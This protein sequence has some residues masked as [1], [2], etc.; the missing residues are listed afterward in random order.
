MANTD[1]AEI[2]WPPGRLAALVGGAGCA[3]IDEEVLARA[4]A[5]V[6]ALQASYVEW[7]WND[8]GILEQAHAA[9]LA[10]P[11]ARASEIERIGGAAHDIRGQGG[12]FGYPLMTTIGSSLCDFCRAITRRDDGQLEVIRAHIDA[13]KAVIDNRLEGNG[14]A[15]GAE[16]VGLLEDA[17]EKH[18]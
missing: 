18:R 12:S 9:A 6:A 16:L 11:S 13:M 2:I 1:A 8:I 3:E 4:E 17:V 5:A 10:E 14:G 7:I 15:Q